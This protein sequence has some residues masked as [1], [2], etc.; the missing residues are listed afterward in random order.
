MYLYLSI[1]CM[2]FISLA[3]CATLKEMEAKRE[4]PEYFITAQKLLD[5]GDYE[6]ALRENEKVLSLYDNI[7]PGDE[8]LFNLG[9][10][11]AHYGYP[12][13]DY[14]KSLDLFKRLVKMFPQ[15]PL[16]GQAKLWI[17]ILQENER[18]NREI[19]ELNKTIKKSKQVDIEIEEKKKELSK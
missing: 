19:E 7:P 8:A 16:A 11:Y 4:T 9:L 15:S 18:L 2:I 10:I 13:R 12:K 1:A 5:Q 6:G 17:G 3:G 14:K